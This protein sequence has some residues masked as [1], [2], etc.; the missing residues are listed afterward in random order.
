MSQPWFD[1]DALWGDLAPYMFDE[2][3]RAGAADEV[4]QLVRLI[5]LSKDS[6]VLDLPCG[7]GRHSLALAKLGFNV[8][9]VDRTRAFIDQ[10]QLEAGAQGLRADWHVGDIRERPPGAPF[11]VVL[12]LLTS[13]GYFDDDAENLRAAGNLH[14][15][16]VPGGTLV[17]DLMG[18]EVLARIFAPRDWRRFPDGALLLEERF[19]EHDW[20]AVRARWTL[21]RDGRERVYEL[22][23]RVYSFIEL[24]GVLEETGFENI[25][26]FGSLVGGPYDPTA[27]RLVVTAAKPL[28]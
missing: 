28:P 14:D 25:R 21:I 22:R 5:G 7:Q 27:A 17:M 13:F 23:H 9:G 12:N 15:C 3:R 1:N 10:A 20:S 16:L 4:E 6:R 8:T 24:R 19:V 11:D 26:A 18:K 2:A